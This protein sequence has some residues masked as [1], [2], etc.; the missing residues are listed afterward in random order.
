MKVLITGCSWIQDMHR[1][2][3]NKDYVFKSWGG[4]GL[5]RIEN[6]LQNIKTEKFD[7]I[8]V[9][10]PTP[11]RNKIDCSSTTIRFKKFISDI[12]KVGKEEA[13][14][15]WLNVY[16]EKIIDISKIN[17]NIIFFMYNVGGYPFRHP[18]DYG[19]DIE[20]KMVNFFKE[21]SISYIRLSFENTSGYGVK[22]EKCEDWEFWNYYHKTNPKNQNKEFRKYWSIIS[23]KG[24]I[25][26]DPHP[27]DRANKIAFGKIN[28]FIKKV[29]GLGGS[30]SDKKNN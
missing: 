11:V 19:K 1:Q 4:Q 5:W 3:D 13:G 8:F 17:E 28:E 7:Y 10:L 29:E 30:K 2:A 9:Q 22:E 25:S 6:Y 27:N 26:L 12:N 23:P 18:F 15:K 14:K 21:S 16:K 20:Y 24:W